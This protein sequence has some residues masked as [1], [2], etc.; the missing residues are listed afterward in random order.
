M[1]DGYSQVPNKLAAN[2]IKILN[3]NPPTLLFRNSMYTKNM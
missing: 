1:A 3:F 2:L